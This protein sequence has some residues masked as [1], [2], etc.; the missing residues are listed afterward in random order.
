VPTKSSS[1]IGGE[2]VRDLDFGAIAN[3]GVEEAASADDG[4]VVTRH[5]AP[6]AVTASDIVIRPVR[7][8]VASLD[9]E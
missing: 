1:R 9:L 8:D 5:H 6:Q 3:G 7:G 2:Q 4:V